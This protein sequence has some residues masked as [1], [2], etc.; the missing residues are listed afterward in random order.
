[1]RFIRYSDVAK[2]IASAQ[3]DAERAEAEHLRTLYDGYA[4]LCAERQCVGC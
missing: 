3:T 1:M 2:R 4:P